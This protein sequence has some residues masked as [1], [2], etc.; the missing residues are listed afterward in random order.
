[1]KSKK[2]NKSRRTNKEIIEEKIQKKIKENDQLKVKKKRIEDILKKMKIYD[3]LHAIILITGCLFA[4]VAV[5]KPP[6]F[7]TI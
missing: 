6:N 4:V 2:T 3:L 1:M 7:R 5:S